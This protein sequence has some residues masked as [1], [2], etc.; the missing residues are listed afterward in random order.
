MNILFLTN[1]IEVNLDHRTE[2]CTNGKTGDARLVLCMAPAYRRGSHAPMTAFF[3]RTN[4]E[5]YPLAIE[6]EYGFFLGHEAFGRDG[7]PLNDHA[8]G[9]IAPQSL[10]GFAFAHRCPDGHAIYAF[11]DALEEG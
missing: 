1:Q 2:I 4:G 9:F 10:R 11:M 3:V 5:P 6:N 8:L 7:V